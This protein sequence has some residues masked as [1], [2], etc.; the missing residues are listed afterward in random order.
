[1]K[2]RNNIFIND[3]RSSIEIFN[4]SIYRL[5][6]MYNVANTVDYSDDAGDD[7]VTRMP[8]SMKAL[9]T[10]LPEGEDAI[11]GITRERAAKEFVRYGDEPWVIVEGK[12]WRL[13]PNRPDFRPRADSKM[14]A[15]RGDA[16]DMPEHDLS[17]GNRS[18]TSIGAYAPAKDGKK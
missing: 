4:T 5:D 3:E 15:N 12:W 18:G 7:R 17:G 8:D 9:A 10:H 1:V 2:L 16:K 6:A 11:T 13:N 14:F